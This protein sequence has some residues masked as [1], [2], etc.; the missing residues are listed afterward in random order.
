MPHRGSERDTGFRVVEVAR[1][2]ER[3]RGDDDIVRAT[4]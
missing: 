4:V 2:I 1:G 3:R